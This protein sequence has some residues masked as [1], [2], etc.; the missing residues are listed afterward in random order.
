ME[1]F[2]I[3]NETDGIL[4]NP[5]PMTREEC[6]QFMIEFRKRFARQGYYL[7]ADGQ[8]I[9]VSEVIFKRIPEAEL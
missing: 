8:R 6:D 3:L 5:E 2:Y 4:C 7:T 1:L 9:G